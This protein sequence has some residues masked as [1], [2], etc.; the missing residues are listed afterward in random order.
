MEL[1]FIETVHQYDVVLFWQLALCKTHTRQTE[2]EKCSVSS[3]TGP[4]FLSKMKKNVTSC[5]AK[6]ER[7]LMW[8]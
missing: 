4:G 3:H 5:T 7:K 1:G 2:R 8:Y 6:D